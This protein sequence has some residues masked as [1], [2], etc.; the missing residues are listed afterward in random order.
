LNEVSKF[1]APFGVSSVLTNLELVIWVH[2]IKKERYEILEDIF[3][4]SR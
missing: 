1:R 2:G 3:K 4:R